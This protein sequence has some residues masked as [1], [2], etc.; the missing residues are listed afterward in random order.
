MSDREKWKQYDLAQSKL[1]LLLGYYSSFI[2]IE[3]KKP[4]PDP[5]QIA[6]WRDKQRS[7]SLLL[8]EVWVDDHAGVA[9]INATYGPILRAFRENEKET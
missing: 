6:H 8:R 3:G 9:N 5:E 1:L 7:M 4:V 2:A